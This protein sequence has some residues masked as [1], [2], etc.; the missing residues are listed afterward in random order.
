MVGLMTQ[1]RD[2][3][4][5]QLLSLRSV[6]SCGFV[7]WVVQEATSRYNMLSLDLCRIESLSDTGGWGIPAILDLFEMKGHLL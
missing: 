6:G 5:L 2:R 1:L 3:K 4:S 7:F